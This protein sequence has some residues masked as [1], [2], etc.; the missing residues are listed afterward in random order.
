MLTE[1]YS[2]LIPDLPPYGKTFVK[3]KQHRGGSLHPAENFGTAVN[4]ISLHT[5][6]A[7]H[8]PMCFQV[9]WERG[10]CM[11]TLR[12]RERVFRKLRASKSLF[13]FGGPK[14]TVHASVWPDRAEADRSITGGAECNLLWRKESPLHSCS[15]HILH[16]LSQCPWLSTLASKQ[17]ARSEDMCMNIKRRNTHDGLFIGM[18]SLCN[19]KGHTRKRSRCDATMT[20]KQSKSESSQSD[21]KPQTC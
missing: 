4:S 18:N 6:Q 19:E 1:L 15:L 3:D 13:S 9:V 2:G 7:T 12:G 8:Q 21:G 17:Y 5:A 11:S 14:P 10:S 16:P 20:M